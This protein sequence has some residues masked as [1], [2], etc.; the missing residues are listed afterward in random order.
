MQRGEIR[1]YRFDNPDKR[2]PVVILTRDSTLKFLGETTVAPVT[3]TIRNIPS[4]ALLSGLDGLPHDCAINFDHIQTVT[5]NKLGA[6]AAKLDESRMGDV[7]NS[8][9]R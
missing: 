3:R 1:W 9:S 4:E 6:L 5:K 2:R 8:F 7:R